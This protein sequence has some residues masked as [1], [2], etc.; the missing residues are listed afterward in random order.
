MP[1]SLSLELFVARDRRSHKTGA[2]ENDCR[3][4]LLFLTRSARHGKS[5]FGVQ[6]S[7]ILRGFQ[8]VLAFDGDELPQTIVPLA[9]GAIGGWSYTC[10]KEAEWRLPE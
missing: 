9:I 1:T 7:G 2:F 8:G 6:F 4:R 3:K 5:N 10:E